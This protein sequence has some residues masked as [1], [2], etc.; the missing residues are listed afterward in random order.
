MTSTPVSTRHVRA[1]LWLAVVLSALG[2]TAC[3]GGEDPSKAL[4]KGLSCVDDSPTCISER[5]AALGGLMSDKSKGWMR[6]QPQTTAYA[7][8]VR[9]F[10]YKQQKR[11][12]SCDELAMGRREAEAGPAALRGPTG[13]GLTPAQISRGVMLSTEVARELDTEFRRRCRA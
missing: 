3:A 13:Q 4:G 5:Q 8:G 7:S 6:Q 10:A 11:Q 9:L 1:A 2:L 12:L